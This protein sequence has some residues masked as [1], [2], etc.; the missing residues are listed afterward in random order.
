[1][2]C[3]KH[4][5]DCPWLQRPHFLPIFGFCGRIRNP[6]SIRVWRNGRPRPQREIFVTGASLNVETARVGAD[7]RGLF[8]RCRRLMAWQGLRC[9]ADGEIFS[10]IQAGVWSG[11]REGQANNWRREYPQPSGFSAKR[12]GMVVRSDIAV[13]RTIYQKYVA[14]TRGGPA[15]ESVTVVS[16]TTSEF[17]AGQFGGAFRKPSLR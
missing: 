11:E 7:W 8:Q 14:T 4:L 1:M 17:I 3:A 13:G 5:A 6:I 16:I 12:Y 15:T 9:R 10:R 2:A